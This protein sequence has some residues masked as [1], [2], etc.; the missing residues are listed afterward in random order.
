MFRRLQRKNEFLRGDVVDFTRR[1][2]ATPSISLGEG[3]V[4]ALVERAMKE[5]DYDE[6]IRDD[7]GNVVGIMRGRRNGPNLLLNAHM[8]TVR[9]EQNEWSR[10]PLEPA[11]EDGRIYGL[12]ASDCKSGIAAA[13]FAGHLLK[14]ALL[15]LDG[16]LV[17]AATVAEQ[18]GRSV[19]VRYLLNETLPELKLWPDY[20]VLAEPTDLELHYGHDGWMECGIEVKGSDTDRVR[21]AAERIREHLRS[22]AGG[23]E[24]GRDVERMS[25]GKP[26]LVDRRGGEHAQLSLDRRLAPGD[27]LQSCL[28]ELK[29]EARTAGRTQE[30]VNVDVDVAREEQRLYTGR[31]VSVQNATPAWETD[32]F[33]HLM[34]RARSV[35][36]AAG[37]ETRPAKW[38]LSRLRMGTA[39]SVLVNEYDIPTVGYGPGS[40][41]AAHAP[42]EWVKED[43]IPAAVYGLAAIAHGLV[44]IPVFGWSTDAV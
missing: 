14:R 36:A 11:A 27:G 33:C 23:P 20:A 4:A 19:G 37:C 12:G 17:V 44:G 39:G 41:E 15:P 18:N 13:V 21:G 22:Y 40:E 25:V 30:A 32:P 42:D 1:L 34:E 35:L 8:D 43:N 16:N 10:P 5:M 3:D 2:T 31:A 38:R 26:R 6:V 9:A 24:A 28:Q 29:A 7:A